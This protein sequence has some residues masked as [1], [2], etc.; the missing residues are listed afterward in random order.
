M[1]RTVKRVWFCTLAVAAALLFAAA[2]RAQA[3]NP[4]M[5]QTLSR[6]WPHS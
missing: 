6:C 3:A 2:Q 5:L 1:I 4:P